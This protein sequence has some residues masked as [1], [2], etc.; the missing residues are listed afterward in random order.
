MY[1]YTNETPF[2]KR[3]KKCNKYFWVLIIQCII[4]MIIIFRFKHSHKISMFLFSAFLFVIHFSV[5]IPNI[6]VSC[7]PQNAAKNERTIG[8]CVCY[9]L[10]F[11]LLV[12]VLINTGF[13]A[14]T[15]YD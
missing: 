14:S 6:K 10:Q 9:G 8:L 3:Q 12:T 13:K 1:I 7:S 4:E 2:L 5:Y 15:I 11:S